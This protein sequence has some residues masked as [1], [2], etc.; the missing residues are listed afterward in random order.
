MYDSGARTSP[1]PG[2]GVMRAD[3]TAVPEPGT[4]AVQRFFV[5]ITRAQ[6]PRPRPAFDVAPT[7]ALAM[8]LLTSIMASARAA[9][10]APGVALTLSLATRLLASILA[11]TRAAFTAPGVAETMPALRVRGHA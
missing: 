10:T 11:S 5:S 8:R 9:F 2:P 4:A 1:H 7:P 3:Y 6:R